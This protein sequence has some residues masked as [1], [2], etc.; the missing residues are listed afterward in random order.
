MESRLLTFAAVR[1]QFSREALGTPRSVSPS[2]LATSIV[3]RL[4]TL[5][6]YTIYPFRCTLAPKG[7]EKR[8][9]DPE[10]A[11]TITPNDLRL[12]R[13]VLSSTHFSCQV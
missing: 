11:F 8:Y 1:I 4:Y 3:H 13:P 2:T 7:L 9:N 10:N 5:P 6:A 12:V